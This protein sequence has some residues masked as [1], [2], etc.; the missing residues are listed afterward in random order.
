MLHHQT[1]R[2]QSGQFGDGESE[3][4][5]GPE[6]DVGQLAGHHRSHLE[7]DGIKAVV[8]DSAPELYS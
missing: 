2:R 7:G 1:P 5:L 8:I 6:P 3:V 4:G